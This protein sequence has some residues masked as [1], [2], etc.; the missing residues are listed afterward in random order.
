MSELRGEESQDCGI[1]IDVGTSQITLHAVKLPEGEV[2]SEVIVHNPQNKVG[3]DVISRVAFAV[4]NAANANEITE[5]VRRASSEAIQEV[6][7]LSGLSSTSV[8]NVVVVGNTVM[9]HLFHGLPVKS[10]TQTPYTVPRKSS[11]STTAAAIGLPLESETAV[12]SPPI[13][14]S[15]IG[16]DALMMLLAS[17]AYD[18]QD[19]M[20]SIDVGTNTEIAVCHDEHV[21]LASAASG[22]A[23]EG[24][25]L[26]CG[27]PAND[28]AIECVRIKPDLSPVITVIGG[29]RPT[30]VCGSGA[31][32][33]VAA[34]LD[35]GLL[36]SRGSLNRETQSPWLR[37]Q[38]SLLY[39]VLAQ[40]SH[41][42]TAKPI[43]V[44]QVDLRMLQQSKAAIFAVVTLLLKKA[45]LNP[46]E[47]ER[48]FLTG[49]FGSGFDIQDA[50]RIGLFPDFTNATVQQMRGGAIAGADAL[51]CNPPLRDV[52]ENL[53]QSVN[54]IEMAGNP[55]FKERYLKAHAY[56]EIE[57]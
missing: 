33:T 11:I 3:F 5:M 55:E 56:P 6:L 22:P 32:S 49:A 42:A 48:V 45:G 52:V 38:H 9:H 7:Q 41:S 34:L 26:E 24:M 17:G 30:G 10:L 19:R 27:M 18:T 36:N 37:K 51:L 29:E 2:A 54:Y 31:I 57:D 15:F 20:V 50:Y 23:F 40:D 1:S 28:G 25:S 44:S 47:V 46:S 4:R 12:Y 13:V 14:E 39:Y 43:Y 21:W 8:R 16:P 53:S 35:A